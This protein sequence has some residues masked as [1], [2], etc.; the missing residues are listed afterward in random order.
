MVCLTWLGDPDDPPARLHEAMRYSVFAGGKRFRPALVS[1]AGETFGAPG[2]AL[3]VAFPLGML[4]L[5]TLGLVQ[6]AVELPFE[7]WSFNHIWPL[8]ILFYLIGLFVARRRY[9]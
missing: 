2:E 6:R 5:T 8:F 7:D 3:A 4:V 1:L 9:A